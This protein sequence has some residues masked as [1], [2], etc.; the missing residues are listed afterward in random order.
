MIQTLLFSLEFILVDFF[1]TY[2][3]IIIICLLLS[4]FIKNPILQKIND[5]SK[6]FIT[7]IGIAYLIVFL[8]ATI[9]ELNISD[10]ESNFFLLN[11]MFGK[12]WFGFWL[13]P[14]LWFSMSQLLRIKSIQKSILLK[15]I[16][17]FFFIISIEKIVIIVTSFH[18][19][20]L[21]SSWTMSTYSYSSNL[22]LEL[23][24]KFS[25]FLISAVFFMM[26]TQ[27]INDWKTIKT[28]SQ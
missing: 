24:I 10:E 6:R 3:I 21:P 23:L 2:G 20:Y 22:F 4:I 15:L 5:Q 16:F 26:I 12:Y 1:S 25:I 17:S 13:Q 14:L 19:D 28:N 8:L 27:K 18:R 7:F 11:R 9:I